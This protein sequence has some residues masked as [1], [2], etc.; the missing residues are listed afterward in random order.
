MRRDR[1]LPI[2]FAASTRKPPSPIYSNV[3]VKFPLTLQETQREMAHRQSTD[4]FSTK[5]FKILE[6]GQCQPVNNGISQCKQLKK[7]HHRYSL[8]IIPRK[9]Q[10]KETYF[11][12]FFD[13]PQSQ[14]NVLNVQASQRFQLLEA[15]KR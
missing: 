15:N 8:P 14:C 4:K 6:H 2:N 9:I 12:F 1:F 13:V 7:K 5:G 3:W 10:K 11:H